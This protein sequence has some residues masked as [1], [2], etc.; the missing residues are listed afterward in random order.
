M[1]RAPTRR[2]GLTLMELMVVLFVLVALAAL[3]VPLVGTGVSSAEIDITFQTMQRL[4]D[5]IMGGNGSNAGY[6]ADMKGLPIPGRTDTYGLPYTV[7]DLL[8]P[9]TPHFTAP[10]P[11]YNVQT[12]R[13][14]RG[15]YIT[16]GIS[17]SLLEIRDS[18]PN[19]LG[20]PGSP[21]VIQWPPVGTPGMSEVQR[22]NFVRLVSYGA[23]GT[24]GTATTAATAIWNPLTITAATW[25][26]DIILYIRHDLPSLD[27]TNY[28]EL[29]KSMG[30]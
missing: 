25:D 24:P 10:P 13:G 15:P 26:D 20:Q 5:A 18:F 29:K 11:F 19:S 16:Q 4:R 30:N 8:S 28:W 17:G 1:S 6:F 21:I 9:S 3:V 7:A 23:N 22:Q 12:Q 14:W 27:W 2:S